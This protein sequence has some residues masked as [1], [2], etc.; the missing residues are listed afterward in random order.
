LFLETI[1]IYS[2]LH[3]SLSSLSI[4]YDDYLEATTSLTQGDIRQS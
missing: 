1:D 2:L 4:I 3:G